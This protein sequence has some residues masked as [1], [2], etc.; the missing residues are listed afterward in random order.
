MKY[1]FLMPA[2]KAA[3]FR[4]AIQSILNQTYKDFQL[5]ISDDCSPEAL[6]AIVDDFDDER[7]VYRRN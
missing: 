5:I 3:F 6:K 2:Y 1:T 7:I 4:E